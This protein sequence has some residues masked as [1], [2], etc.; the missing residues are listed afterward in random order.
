MKELKKYDNRY[1][2]KHK[3][4]LKRFKISFKYN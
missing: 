4:R 3:S 1:I 2:N